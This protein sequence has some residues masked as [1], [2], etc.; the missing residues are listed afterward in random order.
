MSRKQLHKVISNIVCFKM[1]EIDFS[2]EDIEKM[3]F[4]KATLDK[5][6]M[7]ILAGTFDKRFFKTPNMAMLADFLVKYYTKYGHA[8]SNKVLSSMA[9]AYADKYQDKNV[10]IAAVNELLAEISTFDMQVPDDVASANM[11]EFIR[12][13]AFY[14]ALYDNA[15]MLGRDED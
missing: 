12:K 11:K 8:P 3:L 5:K 15:D 2:R 13:N 6:W 1:M 10:S 9:K 7:N 4:K 14:N